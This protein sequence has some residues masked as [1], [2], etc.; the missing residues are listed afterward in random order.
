KK[1]IVFCLEP[2]G[3]KK[4]NF[5]NSLEEVVGVLS[6]VGKKNLAIAIA[7]SDIIETNMK[8]E[9]IVHYGDLIAHAYLDSLEEVAGSSRREAA[10]PQALSMPNDILFLSILKKISYDGV[11]T[12][13]NDADCEALISYKEAWNKL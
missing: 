4:T 5:L 7:S 3:P 6:S 2:L 10:S 8:I 13:P 1:G 9:D 11:I 12:L